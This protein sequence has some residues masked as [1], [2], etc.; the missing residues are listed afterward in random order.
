M[1]VGI[2][3]GC[4]RCHMLLCRVSKII[5]AINIIM[6]NIYHFLSLAPAPLFLLGFIYSII[7]PSHA[8]GHDYSMSVMWLV[9]MLA[10]LTPWLIWSQQRNLTR[11]WKAAVICT[12]YDCPWFPVVYFQQV[13]SMWGT[14]YKIVDTYHTHRTLDLHSA[15]VFTCASNYS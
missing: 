9:M 14:P 8:C 5:S 13:Q 2:C 7:N 10:H 6:R 3:S 4:A 11:N 1:G 15:M 12:L